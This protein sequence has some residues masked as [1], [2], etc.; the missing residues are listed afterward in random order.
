MSE[1]TGLNAELIHV[2]IQTIQTRSGATELKHQRYTKKSKSNTADEMMITDL[3]NHAS[4]VCEFEIH[5]GDN[6][7]PND[8][9]I[10]PIHRITHDA[11]CIFV[12]GKLHLIFENGHAILNEAENKFYVE[13]G[14]Q[15][16]LRQ[17]RLCGLMHVPSKYQ[18]LMCCYIPT[19][20]RAPARYRW[21]EVTGICMRE[22]TNTMPRKK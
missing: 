5:I 16:W 14:S 1:Q 6:Q 13:E 18:L 9:V 19:G 10:S 8:R 22:S 21:R 20:P 4:S 2:L 11:R 3:K 17:K 15:D 7:S 12:E